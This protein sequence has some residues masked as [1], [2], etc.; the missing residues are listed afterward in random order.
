[1][2]YNWGGTDLPSGTA[3]FDANGFP[4][5]TAGNYNISF[6]VTTA[7]YTITSA[8]TTKRFDASTFN[9]YPNPTQNSWNF[10]KSNENIESIQIVDLLGKTIRS[11][12]TKSNFATVDASGLTSG[13]YFAKITTATG[14]TT[15]KLIKD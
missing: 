11:V 6:N 13:I 9:V 8:L 15:L 5:P 2:P 1:L 7:A 4:I 14:T 3:V 12:G 10:S